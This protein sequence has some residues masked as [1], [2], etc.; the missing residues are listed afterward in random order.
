MRDPSLSLIRPAVASDRDL[1]LRWVNRPESLAGKLL[2]TGP[3]PAEIHAAWFTRRLA[4]RRSRIFIIET[5]SGPAGQTRFD[6]GDDGYEI[7][8]FIAAGRRR[9]GLAKKALSQA[10]AAI[11]SEDRTARFM[12]RVKPGNSASLQLFRSL[13][14][15]ITETR[16]DFIFLSRTGKP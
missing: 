12:A 5:D 4:D 7:D 8:I 14:F 11:V 10:M 6:R 16:P 1:L 15:D 9:G 13:G 3:I 2:T